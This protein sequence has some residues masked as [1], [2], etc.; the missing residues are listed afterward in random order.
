MNLIDLVINEV[1]KGLKY[2]TQHYQNES[3]P[4]PANKIKQEPLNEFERNHSAG[5]MR[6][7]ASV[8]SLLIATSSSLYPP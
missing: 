1:D 4:Y 3:S 2:S 8:L 6:V 5:L 7:K